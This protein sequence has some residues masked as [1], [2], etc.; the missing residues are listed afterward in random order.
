MPAAV[1]LAAGAS[2]RFGADKLTSEIK[3]GGLTAPLSVHAVQPWLDVFDQVVLV[4]RPQGDAV[5]EALSKQF[6]ASRLEFVVCENAAQGMS[7][8]IASGVSAAA[9]ANGWLIGLADMPSIPVA[10]IQSVCS[11]ISD[12]KPLAAP[13]CDN[14]RGHPVGFNRRYFD[15]LTTLSG[16]QGARVLLQR[17]AALI[18]R[19]EMSDPGVLLDIDKPSDILGLNN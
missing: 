7:A 16:D 14:Q 1:V 2:S 11:A 4:L 13:F 3:L 12:G 10:A 17:D 8:S 18:H 15:E 9:D 5:R 19:I 6:G